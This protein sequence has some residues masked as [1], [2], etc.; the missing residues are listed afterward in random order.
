VKKPFTGCLC[1][2]EAA[3]GRRVTMTA[4]KAIVK[5]GRL[6]LDVPADWPEGTEVEIHPV[7]QAGK[8]A[9]RPTTPEEEVGEEGWSNTP[10]A[11]PDW[12]RWYD[13]LEPLTLTPEEEAD[14]EAWLRKAGDYATAKMDKDVEDLSR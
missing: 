7:G 9:D 12:L 4:I 3:E 1:Q 14:A 5:G 6:E 11:I 10:E 2:T 13:S 8:N